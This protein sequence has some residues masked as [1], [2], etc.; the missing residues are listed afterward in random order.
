MW[1]WPQMSL[2]SP[3]SFTLPLEYIESIDQVTVN[4]DPDP[5]EPNKAMKGFHSVGPNIVS[6]IEFN[7]V[8][9]IP[10]YFMTQGD[11]ASGLCGGTSPACHSQ[12]ET[13]FLL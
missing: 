9:S 5:E 8:K 2:L 12:I 6:L 11:W 3:G 13:L 10:S 4:T 7:D 1:H